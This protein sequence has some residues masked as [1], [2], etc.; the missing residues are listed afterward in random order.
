MKGIAA[1]FKLGTFFYFI[2]T[3][4]FLLHPEHISGTDGVL[5]LSPVNSCYMDMCVKEER[6]DCNSTYAYCIH[7]KPS[8]MSKN[9]TITCL[10]ADKIGTFIH[11]ANT[12]TRACVYVVQ[13]S[14]A[15]LVIILC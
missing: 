9:R 11:H 5:A 6:K 1:Q 3:L 13:L 14:S 12:A 4:N 2:G 8:Q 10:S 7:K 15:L